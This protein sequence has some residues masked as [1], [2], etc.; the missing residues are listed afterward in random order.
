ML[1]VYVVMPQ[2]LRLS[3]PA[4]VQAMRVREVLVRRWLPGEHR[5]D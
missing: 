2:G 1:L 5:D 3:E 4:C